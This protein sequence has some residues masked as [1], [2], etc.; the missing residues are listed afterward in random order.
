MIT[1]EQRF[2]K[3]I[4]HAPEAVTL[5]GIDG[6]L[7]YASASALRMFGYEIEDILG[8]NPAAFTHPDDL[9]RVIACLVDLMQQPGKVVTLEYRF[10]HKDGRWRWIE[11]TISNLLAESG[12]NAV[13]FNFRD[14]TE[15]IEAEKALRESE[16]R[17]R[18]TFRTS[19]DAINLNRLTDGLFVDV[20]E[21][22]S[23]VT[24]YTRADVI[25]KTSTEINLWHDPADREKLV[26]GLLANGQVNNLEARFRL[27]NG[28][29]IRALMSAKVIL[30]DGI[31]HTL[32]VTRDIE[33]LKQ[34]E[35]AL[36]RSEERYRTLIEQ[37]S[38]GIFLA[39]SEGNYIDV[40]PSG[41]AMLGYNRAELLQMNMRDL[42]YSDAEEKYAAALQRLQSGRD[43][44]VEHK[45]KRKDGSPL[46]VEISG[47]LL[48]DGRIQ[49]MVRDISERKR[50]EEA[51]RE[52][53]YQIEM[54]LNELR[55]T[56]SQLVQQERL[57]AVGQLAAG[58]AHDFNN[59]LGVITLHTQMALSTPAV[60]ASVRTRLETVAQQTR[61]AADLAQQVLDFGRRSVLH[62]SPVDLVTLMTEQVSLMQRTLPA[63]INVQFSYAAA[64]YVVNA[65]TTRLQQMITNL[66]INARDA[67][68][69]GGTLI[70]RLEHALD[71]QGGSPQSVHMI[72]SDS[73]T[74]IDETILPQIFEPFFT[75]KEPGRGTGLGLAQVYGIVQ[76]HHGRIDVKSKLGYGT[77]FEVTF[78]LYKD[79]LQPVANHHPQ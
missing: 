29:V 78:P 56:Q 63:Q 72:F 25:G 26:A 40:N 45:L 16:E 64:E 18:L 1:E 32:S 33:H 58:I 48:A 15:R 36:S 31:P 24:G 23:Q 62:T 68:P 10:R 9:P 79:Q 59:I 49:G 38:D 6:T 67:M 53:H 41:C 51:L 74:G 47:K 35:D 44:L 55:R 54:T 69:E 27:K 77:M 46:L 4:E 39:N 71:R 12:V 66:V 11:S 75:T 28:N 17:F 42:F 43:K 76:Q 34:V 13:V 22:F 20:N 65:D 21:G 8:A 5:L 50:V 61:L 19:P 14:I 37:A 73:G 57:A 3:L 70:I 7:Q 2:K 52:S 60:P 30:L